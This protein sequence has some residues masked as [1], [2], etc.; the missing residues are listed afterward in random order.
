MIVIE[1][2]NGGDWKYLATHIDSAGMSL[3]WVTTLEQADD[4]GSVKDAQAFIDD[5]LTERYKGKL[6]LLTIMS[7]DVVKPEAKP[8]P[9]PERAVINQLI[10]AWEA[11]P[12]GNHSAETIAKWLR[13]RMAPA[14]S[15][16]R[17]YIGREPPK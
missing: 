2:P 8:D 7:F 16:A 13:D 1:R 4:F 9:N 10:D 3:Q 15:F 6:P 12:G 5:R 11:L 17:G 14:I